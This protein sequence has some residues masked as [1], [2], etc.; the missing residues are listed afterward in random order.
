M[1]RSYVAHRSPQ[2]TVKTLRAALEAEGPSGLPRVGS[3]SATRST[4]RDHQVMN[5]ISSQCAKLKMYDPE[6]DIDPRGIMIKKPGPLR[7]VSWSENVEET[8]LDIP[9][10]PR[11]PRTSTTPGDTSLAPDR[12]TSNFPSLRSS[13]KIYLN[14]IR[15]SVGR[16]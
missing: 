14:S 11:T 9:G 8:E 2:T 6:D 13:R 10:T 7:T 3:K 1:S 16:P 5:G 4:P 15:Y 12:T